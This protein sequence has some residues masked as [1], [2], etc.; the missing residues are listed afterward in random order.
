MSYLSKLINRATDGN[1]NLENNIIGNYKIA[2]QHGNNLYVYII[3]KRYGIY[4][5]HICTIN[6]VDRLSVNIDDQDCTPKEL[7]DIYYELKN[8]YPTFKFK[9]HTKHSL[10]KKMGLPF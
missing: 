3:H 10:F 4:E 9:I 2:P 1:L 5:K 8:I 6:I 7:L